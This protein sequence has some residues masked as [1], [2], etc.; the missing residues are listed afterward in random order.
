[1]KPLNNPNGDGEHVQ[2]LYDFQRGELYVASAL[3]LWRAQDY[4]GGGN[5]GKNWLT[6]EEFQR[7]VKRIQP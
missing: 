7:V 1:L 2:V 3:Q 4:Q 5:P 6:D